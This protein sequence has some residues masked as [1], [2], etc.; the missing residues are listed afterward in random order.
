MKKVVLPGLEVISDKKTGGVQLFNRGRYEDALRSIESTNELLRELSALVA[1]YGY[2]VDEDLLR[3]VL[4]LGAG[5]FHAIAEENFDVWAASHEYPAFL[6]APGKRA[7]VEAVPGELVAAAD[8]LLVQIREAIKRAPI[9]VEDADI[10]FDL[11]RGALQIGGGFASRLRAS[12][13]DKVGADVVEDGKKLCEVLAELRAI[14]AK[15]YSVALLV[16]SLIGNRYADPDELP[17]LDLAT[18]LPMMQKYPFRVLSP[19]AARTAG[20][21][22]LACVRAITDASIRAAS[23]GYCSGM[24]AAPAPSI[25]SQQEAPRP[26]LQAGHF[27][28]VV[29]E[30][31]KLGFEV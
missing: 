3:R 12:C 17:V 29:E 22:R 18:V 25:E 30:L 28:G 27:A 7:A 19:D 2:K 6:I 13:S 31:Q 26:S 21:D 11:D 4:R 23:A 10:V 14:D 8:D 16:Q 20:V 1:K 9:Q 24:G 15:G 5:V